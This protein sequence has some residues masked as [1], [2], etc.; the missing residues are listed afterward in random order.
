V[1]RQRGDAAGMRRVLLQQLRV[2]AHVP[3]AHGAVG[4][5]RRDARAVGVEGDGVDAAAVVVVAAHGAARRQVP[6]PRAAV[7]RAGGGEAAVGRERGGAH[8]V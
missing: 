5:G 7:V 4:A 8:P 2:A 1:V 3:H 6:Q